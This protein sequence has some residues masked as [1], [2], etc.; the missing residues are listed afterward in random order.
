[1]SC[2]I[3]Q[4]HEFSPVGLRIAGEPPNWG[5]Q[6]G[7]QKHP[8]P[9]EKPS[10]PTTRGNILA[11]AIEKRTGILA[12]PPGFARVFS[13]V[14]PK[15]PVEYAQVFQG[16]IES[17]HPKASDMQTVLPVKPTL[18]SIPSQTTDGSRNHRSR[19]SPTSP[20]C[21]HF[22]SKGTCGSPKP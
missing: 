10:W 20:S 1:M 13:G 18:E 9:R 4:T 14:D 15:R 19:T 22:P 5:G 6:S 3:P 21:E 16:E 8:K 7:G 17:W 2:S 11:G 12:D